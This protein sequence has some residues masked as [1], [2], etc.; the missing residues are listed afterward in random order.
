MR[1]YHETWDLPVTI[2]NCANNYGPYQFPEKVIPFFTTLA[3]GDE[4]LPL[5]ASTENRREWIH[6]LDHCRAIDAILDRGGSARP[7]T[8][9]RAS[10][11]AS[12]RSPTRSS[13][14]S[15]SRRR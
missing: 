6:A 12:S 1:A 5:Y 9:A 11:A 4:P 14:T 3:L 8:S 15:A 10:S 2:T 7:I 13:G